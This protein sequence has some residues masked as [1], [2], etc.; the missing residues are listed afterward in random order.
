VCCDGTEAWDYVSKHAAEVQVVL[1]DKMMPGLSGMEVFQNIKDSEQCAH[2][3]TLLQSADAYDKHIEESLKAGIFA[4]VTKPF[5][6]SEL[7]K[8]LKD[9]FSSF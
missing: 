8:C 7:D 9:A 6:V 2:I 5:D 4:Y 1:L 3:V